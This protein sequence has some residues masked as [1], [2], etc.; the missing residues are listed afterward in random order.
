MISIV[1]P[2]RNEAAIIESSVRLMLRNLESLT[3]EWELI[4]VDDGS[5]DDSLKIAQALEREFAR[6]RVIS[7]AAHR[8]RGYAIR[9][10][11]MQARGEIVITTEIDSSWGDEI[12][13]RIAAEFDKRPDAD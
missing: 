1:S 5:D 7:Y 12:V 8:G 6:L 13:A 9:R 4:I 3:D 11:I 2:F 10:G